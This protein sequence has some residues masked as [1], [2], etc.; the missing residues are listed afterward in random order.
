MSPHSVDGVR[1]RAASSTSS[2]TAARPNAAA[3]ARA[4][5]LA[6]AFTIQVQESMASALDGL[7]KDEDGD[8]ETDA[9]GADDPF[10]IGTGAATGTSDALSGLAGL[11]GT[12]LASAG[13]PD[14]AQLAQQLIAALGGSSSVAAPA[15]SRDASANAAVVADVARRQGVDPVAAVAMMLV[16]SGGNA[17]AVGDGGTSFGL[18]QLHEGG[19]LTAS[20]L[21][22]EQAFDPR[23][24]AEVS[25]RSYAHER[26]KGPNRSAGEIAAASQRPADPTGYAQRVDA[27]MNRARALLAGSGNG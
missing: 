3:R 1:P 8:G 9:E 13:A 25:L 16:E 15:A 5:E 23:M 4:E 14:E 2:G 27:A 26:A 24:N 21:T 20:G 6:L 17:G 18:F 22:P 10:G 19:M 7:S 12:D 11:G